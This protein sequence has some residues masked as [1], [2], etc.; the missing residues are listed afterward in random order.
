MTQVAHYP[1]LPHQEEAPGLGTSSALA[2][3][4]ISH[5]SALLLFSLLLPKPLSSEFPRRWDKK[6]AA[7][8]GSV[9]SQV[10]NEAL[11]WFALRIDRTWGR[12]DDSGV[13]ST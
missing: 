2:E 7:T 5:P 11:S 1:L 4:L 13:K 9:C 10:G 8:G 12:R 3:L 6:E